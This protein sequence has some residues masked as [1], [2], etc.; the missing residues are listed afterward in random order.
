MN[1]K[2]SIIMPVY[3]GDKFLRESIESVLSQTFKDFEFII[4]NDGS[5]D[6]SLSIIKEYSNKDSR[7][8]II[9]QKNKGVS[10]SRNN[11]IKNSVG[12]YIAFIDS[13]DL[14]SKEKL[15]I[16]INTFLKDK[17]LK[18]CGTWGMVINES[19]KEIRKFEYPPIIDKEI[20]IKSIY[21][22]PFITS[23]IIFKKEILNMNKLFKA[24]I[25]LAED[26]EFITNYIYKNKCININDYLIKYRIHKNNSDNSFYK[27]IKFK[28]LAM[29]IRLIAFSRLV[30]FIF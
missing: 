25:K 9:D 19:G 28:I 16:Q 21:K 29:K 12:E 14:W 30:K 4:I 1:G 2:V 24:K 13:D 6:S 15:E 26:Y 27:K 3:N 10:T 23:S 22:Y 11:G 8:K 7:I 17:D 18:I 20:K 5:T